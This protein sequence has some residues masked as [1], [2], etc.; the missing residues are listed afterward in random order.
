MKRKLL[1]ISQ[2]HPYRRGVHR[3][4]PIKTLDHNSTQKK[5]SKRTPHD[6]VRK[7][8]HIIHFACLLAGASH[9]HLNVTRQRSCHR[10]P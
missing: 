5:E 10:S 7:V 3:I 9:G 6:L 2:M 8:K 1:I 4:V